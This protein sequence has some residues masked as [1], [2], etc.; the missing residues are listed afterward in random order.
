MPSTRTWLVASL[1]VLV[2]LGA[3]AWALHDSSPTVHYRT[4]PLDRGSMRAVV[5]AS[6]TVNPVTQVQVSSQVSGQIRELF[7]D[8]NS[9]VKQ[10]QLIA[11][12]DP[13]T[14]EYRVRQAQADVEA[15]RASVMTAQAQ[16]Q[17]VLAQV[18]RASVALREAE[19]DLARKRDLVRQSFISPAE[20]D[21]AESR[22][23]TLAEELKA[24][25]AQ[26]A[27][28]RAQSVN[29]QA[30]VRQREA[31]LAQSEVDLRRTQIR[32]PVDGVVI[33]RSVEVGQTVAVSLQA[34]ELFIIARN[35][36]DMQVDASIDEADIARVR[37]GMSVDF[38]IDALPGSRFVGRVRQVRKASVVQQ[39]VV[40]YVAVVD[41]DNPGARLLPGMT[42]NVRIVTETRDAA[43][44]VPNAALRARVPGVEPRAD[45]GAAPPSGAGDG[46]DGGRGTVGRLY[47]LDAQGLPVAHMVRLGIAEGTKTELLPT[48][49][50]KQGV[51]QDGTKVI[52]AVETEK[53]GGAN[54]AGMARLLR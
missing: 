36:S 14:F 11:R 41:F 45:D 24:A 3:G 2:A 42:A 38:A 34:P 12:L 6:G 15:S 22:V 28:A 7:V 35:L 26:V 43:L 46:A 19:R 25:E 48:D 13:Q 23:A 4:A 10:G 33:R 17:Q 1:V 21:V 51:L 20:S 32:S 47:T 54:P 37:P 9:E 5:A 40:T 44:R 39:N 53:C 18:S 31:A 50:Q 8:F 52:V 16:V 30:V 49:A 27:V 29:A